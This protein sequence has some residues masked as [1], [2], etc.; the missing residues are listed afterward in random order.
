[1]RG[2]STGVVSHRPPEARD[3]S[4]KRA[5]IIDQSA[6][7][8]SSSADA[9]AQLGVE[10]RQVHGTEEAFQAAMALDA[11]V[12]EVIA[13]GD[14]SVTT[15]IASALAL[16]GRSTII[17]PLRSGNDGWL[18]SAGVDGKKLEGGR[19]CAVPSLRV[20]RLGAAWPIVCSTVAIGGVGPLL[21]GI[22]RGSSGVAAAK[23]LA[24]SIG[25]S[26][27]EW[28]VD[29]ASAPWGLVCSAT[30]AI[31]AA[32][33]LGASQTQLIATSFEPAK[34]GGLLGLVRGLAGMLS[35]GDG[36][37]VQEL[38]LEGSGDL[39]IDGWT[40]TGPDVVRIRRGPD[41]RIIG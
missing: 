15:A 19:V 3:A 1:M 4:L 2:S 21:G 11:D 6:K 9:L 24:T 35:G 40:T 33:S 41:V 34:G 14:A 26:N 18:E 5:A 20:E 36:R 13:V 7:S 32:V 30:G 38:A 25:S 37:E 27:D 31:G 12:D 16:T 29:G 39:T 17:R 10:T 28:S 8:L 22:H 23:G